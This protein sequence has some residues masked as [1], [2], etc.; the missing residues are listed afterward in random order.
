MAYYSISIMQ[1]IHSLPLCTKGGEADGVD[2]S[3]RA[4]IAIPVLAPKFYYFD[5]CWQVFL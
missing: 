2:F 1:L 3:G 5:A 4:K